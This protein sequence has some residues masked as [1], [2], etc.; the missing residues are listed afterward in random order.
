MLSVTLRASVLFVVVM[1]LLSA[2]Q[3]ESVFDLAIV[4]LANGVIP[5][6]DLIL[7]AEIVLVAVALALMMIV[8]L[9]F[10]A[11]VVQQ[12]KLRALF[13]DYERYQH[14]PS[15]SEL[16]PGLAKTVAA[17]RTARMRAGDIPAAMMLWSRYDGSPAHVQA[18]A[19]RG[20]KNI[21]LRTDRW[22]PIRIPVRLGKPH[23]LAAVGHKLKIRLLAYAMRVSSLLMIF[24]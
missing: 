3:T 23:L 21:L 11:Y 18:V 5:G 2:T 24:K 20:A 10:R 6:T 16:L 9:L 12:A 22:A 7:P 4:F 14:D 17:I 13:P 1:S 8:A 19:Y 15:F